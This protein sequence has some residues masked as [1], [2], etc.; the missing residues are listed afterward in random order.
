M[1]VQEQF[2]S[3][4]QR[5]RPLSLSRDFSDEEMARDLDAHAK[6]SA[7]TGQVQQELPPVRCH[8]TLCRTSLWPLP[9]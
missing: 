8:P 2:L 4:R 6:G 7:G 1:S 5:Y 9:Q 3:Q